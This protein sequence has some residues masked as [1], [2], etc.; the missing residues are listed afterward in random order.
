MHGAGRPIR[1][2]LA[3]ALLAGACTAIGLADG[4]GRPWRTAGEVHIESRATQAG[5]IFFAFEIRK[6]AT[7]D[8]PERRIPCPEVEIVIPRTDIPLSPVDKAA[9]IV[10][11]LT[12]NACLREALTFST[13]LNPDTGLRDIIKWEAKDGYEVRAAYL[14]DGLNRPNQTGA[15]PTN[16][17]DRAYYREAISA[18]PEFLNGLI[19]FTGDA[20][21]RSPSGDAGKAT[22]RIGDAE[23]VVSTSPGM[24]PDII[25]DIVI[26]ELQLQ[27]VA[28]RWYDPT[29]DDFGSKFPDLDFDEVGIIV[30]R[31]GAEGIAVQSDDQS[32]MVDVAGMF[33]VEENE[34]CLE[35]LLPSPMTAGQLSLLGVLRGEQG[36]TTVIAYAF[37]TGPPVAG[38][39]GTFCGE[40]SLRPLTGNGIVCRGVFNESGRFECEVFVPDSAQGRTLHFQAFESGS[41]PVICSSNLVTRTIQ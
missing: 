15:N 31:L 36:R 2:L 5:S 13:E 41:C 8:E 40:S 10:Q 23:V 17:R 18:D 20:S 28:A 4:R 30:E 34:S 7:T 21:G 39:S 14:R 9:L 33:D 27:G 38:Q 37:A 22:V 3:V 24:P 1:R 16:E 11:T 29:L 35:L 26:I 19:S 32:L 12:D 25:E 6:L